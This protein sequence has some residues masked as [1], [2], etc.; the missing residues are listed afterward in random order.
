[1]LH[2]GFKARLAFVLRHA[3]MEARLLP[4]E[5]LKIGWREWVGLPDLR[6]GAIKAKI[7][8]GAR[9]SAL[10][11]Y[12]IEPFRRGGALCSLAVLLLHRLGGDMNVAHR[13][14]HPPMAKQLLDRVQ[15][16]A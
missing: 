14:R 8:T 9:T 7:D 2:Q 11:A 5:P 3:N 16:D 13:G 4:K 10:H 6:V 15:V 1:M 12:R